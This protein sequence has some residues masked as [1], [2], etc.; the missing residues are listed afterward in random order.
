MLVVALF[1]FGCFLSKYDPD[2]SVPCL[3]AWNTKKL[4][5]PA[6]Q[7]AGEAVLMA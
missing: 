1:Y 4:L 5:P 6:A 2:G 3:P 7:A